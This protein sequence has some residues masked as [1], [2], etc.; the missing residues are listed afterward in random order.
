MVEHEHRARDGTFVEPGELTARERRRARGGVPRGT[1]TLPISV[2]RPDDAAAASV[3]HPDAVTETPPG[4][5]ARD[6]GTAQAG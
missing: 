6:E 1:P 5:P 4:D 2:I 3:T